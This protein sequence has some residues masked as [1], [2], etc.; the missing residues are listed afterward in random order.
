MTEYIT[1]DDISDSL[2]KGRVTA[3]E[4]ASANE[5]VDRIASSYGVTAVTVTPLAKKLAAAV[6]C[7]ECCLNLIGTDATA[8]IG[9]RQEDVYSIKYKV[10]DQ[11]VKD[12]EARILKADFLADD[13]KDDKEERGAWTRAVSI[14]RS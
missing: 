1:S 9:D 10:Y 5:Y 13:E 3:A 11:L 14:Y 7:R 6:A 4:I 2:L 8:V 12:T